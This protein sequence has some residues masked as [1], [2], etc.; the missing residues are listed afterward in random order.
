MKIGLTFGKYLPFH[1]G[2]KA[3]LDFALERCDELK[4]VVCASD[5][6]RFPAD[7]RARW[8]REAY[9]G[10]DRLEIIPLDYREQDLPNT[11]ESSKEVARVWSV[12]F[13]DLVSSADL[14][15]TSEPYGD[16]VAE[17]MQLTHV[18][19]DPVRLHH[20]ISASRIRADI[21]GHW[22]YIMPSVRRDLGFRV[23]IHGTEST[24]KT[25]L[26]GQLADVFEGTPIF[27][28]GRE[29]IP[30]SGSFDFED[31]AEVVRVHS[32]WIAAADYS[33]SPLLF[34]DTNLFT[35]ESYA[36]HF[37]GR[38]LAWTPEVET[39]HRAH[40]DLYLHREVP[41]VQDG[42]RL[43]LE[44]RDALDGSHRS[45]LDEFGVQYV[46][47][48]GT[49]LERQFKAMEEVRMAARA[50]FSRCFDPESND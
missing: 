32:E 11:S 35:T 5:G 22:R 43:Q 18:P 33:R 36:R 3:L 29:V 25:T 49:Y 21:P 26:V 42:T 7:H 15:F 12:R 30:D 16:F 37:Y 39:L 44:E 47:L 20:P 17:Y 45:V 34:I 28:A 38:G 23:V 6:E 27:E 1:T 10:L 40:L 8:I 48:S 13:L 46:E 19:F 41:F 14:V 24:G 2:H 9:P 31:L 4:V 50:H